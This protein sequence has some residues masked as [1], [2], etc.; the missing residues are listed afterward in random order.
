MSK[1]REFS[2]PVKVEILTRCKQ[3]T[4]FRCEVCG[5]V[6]THGE[7]DHTDADALQID[8]TRKLTAEDGKFMCVPCHKAKTKID[9]AII[10]KVKRIEARHLGANRPKGK[11][12][13]R[14]FPKRKE[15]SSKPSLPPRQLYR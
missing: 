15:R 11:I 10:A 3:P 12:A 2:K 1:R 9:V 8:K 13:S 7:I 14:G 6:V 5:A 4:G